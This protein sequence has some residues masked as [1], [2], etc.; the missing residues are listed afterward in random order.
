MLFLYLPLVLSPY[1][2]QTIF[3]LLSVL[4]SSVTSTSHFTMWSNLLSIPHT[5]P[6]THHCWAAPKFLC[7]SG[8]HLT[9]IVSSNILGTLPSF[10]QFVNLFVSIVCSITLVLMEMGNPMRVD[11]WGTQVLQPCALA[12]GSWKWCGR[13]SFVDNCFTSI[14][15]VSPLPHKTALKASAGSHSESR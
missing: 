11:H 5:V 1:L 8:S 4:R 12:A 9:L 13:D 10:L 14:Q 2:I 7:L 15:I 6:R 3:S